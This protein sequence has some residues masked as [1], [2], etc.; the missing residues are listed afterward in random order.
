[1][2]TYH[3]H[4][5][6]IVQGVGFRPFVYQKA[7][8]HGMKGWVNNTND[9][10]HIQITDLKEQ[11]ELFLKD[12]LDHLPPL[13][14]VTRHTFEQT[15]FQDY[16]SFE[17]V[18]STATTQPKLLVT[19]DV[20]LCEDCRNELQN[21]ENRRYQYPFI[22]CTNCGPR[23]SIIQKLPYDRPYTTMNPFEM[24]PVCLKEYHNP[25]ER[26]HFSQT[27]SCPECKVEM[28]LYI[29]GSILENFEDLSF[30]IKQ[31]QAGKII[32]IKGI[33]GYLLT[34]DATQ[35]QAVETLRTRKHRPNKPFAL[36]YPS[37]KL[38]QRDAFVSDHEAKEL[39]ST[40]SP[41]VLLQTQDVLATDLALE[42]INKGL[43]KIGVMLPYTP[44]LELLLHDFGK[45]IVATSANISNSTILFEDDKAQRELASIADLILMN[46]RAITV[47]QDDGV[48]QFTPLHHLKITLRRSR[49]KAPIYINSQLELPS[50][51]IFAPGAMLKSVFGFIYEKNMYI[52]Q[53]LGNTASYDAQQNYEQTFQHLQNIFQIPF[54]NVITDLH[55]DYFATRFGKELAQINQVEPSGVQHHKAH[56]WSVLGEHNL[57]HTKTPILGVIWDGT[58]LGEDG[59]IWGGEFFKFENGTMDRVGHLEEF[60]FILGD[61]MPKEPRIAAFALGHQLPESEPYL[62]PKFTDTEWQIYKKLVTQTSLRCSSMGRLFDAVAS[63]LFGYDI[64]SFEAE[65]SMRLENEAS[66]F[67]YHKDTNLTARL[68]ETS[69]ELHSYLN[70][71]TFPT[72]FVDFL[73]RNIIEDLN[74]GVHKQLIAFKFHLTLVDYIEQMA[75]AFGVKQM[76]FS[77]GVFQ[78]A[79]LVDLIYEKLH[80]NFQLF[81]HQEFSPNDEGIAFGQLLSLTELV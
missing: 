75:I 18:E 22:T 65:A 7:I 79:L 21:P 69:F 71:T 74:K 12:L 54:D 61:K 31:W 66:Q 78:N 55:P 63:L 36:M 45:P 34:C 35:V 81:F 67:F 52:S 39:Q 4:I 15:D 72:H 68:K 41:I 13:A 77:G 70:E 23:Y 64:H 10:V 56:F 49:G 59:H 53:Y 25:M 58:G 62:K 40:A 29:D 11:A 1:L 48:V 47:P 46:N 33:G 8:H 27:N 80:P 26:R 30:I 3:I 57:I 42:A 24:C 9:G 16:T 6:G 2:H 20:A 14:I 32:A 60:P 44:L 38:L 76:A 28:Q 51:S 5:Q 43:S 73:Y 37:L 19:P 17:I 50:Q